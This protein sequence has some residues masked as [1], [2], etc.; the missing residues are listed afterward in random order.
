MFKP[1]VECI[2]TTQKYNIQFAIPF[3]VSICIMLFEKIYLL[4]DN[5][6]ELFNGGDIIYHSIANILSVVAQL[7]ASVA[8]AIIFYYCSE[9]LNKKRNMNLY[10]DFR[11]TLLITLYFIM[12]ILEQF[13]NFETIRRSTT[14]RMHDVYDVK[15]F[16]F[17]LKNI[18]DEK[19]YQYLLNQLKQYL[20][21]NI[22]EL[23]N[24]M[25]GFHSTIK[26]LT[27]NVSNYRYFRNSFNDMEEI[28]NIFEDLYNTFIIYKDEKGSGEI[29]EE[30]AVNEIAELFIDF[31]QSYT[32]FE[33]KLD[34]FMTAINRKR[35]VTFMRLLD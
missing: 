5:L 34:T 31:V 9:F 13:D 27:N 12:D 14:K 32:D 2:S 33:I 28:K 26:E 21:I 25:R 15:P 24:Y 6:P 11:R 19:N 18:E 17:T 29:D 1:H 4:F 22:N 30:A 35:M 20:Q 3:I 7:A 23:S 8:A 10:I 16:Y